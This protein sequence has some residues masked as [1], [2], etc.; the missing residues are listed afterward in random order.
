MVSDSYEEENGEVEESQGE[1]NEEN[2]NSQLEVTSSEAMD[3][4]AG[5]SSEKGKFSLLMG[6]IITSIPALF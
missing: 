1:E 4:V 2:D 3:P 5:C 6:R